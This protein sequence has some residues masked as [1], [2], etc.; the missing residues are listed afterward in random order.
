METPAED[1]ME[2]SMENTMGFSVSGLGPDNGESSRREDGNYM[3][4][5]IKQ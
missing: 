5:A 4:T 3:K 2:S 1:N